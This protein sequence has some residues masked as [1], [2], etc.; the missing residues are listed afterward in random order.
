MANE[1]E[2]GMTPAELRQR[3]KHLGLSQSSLADALGVARNTVAR[4]E[5]GEL[6]IGSPAMV[7]LAG[8]DPVLGLFELEGAGSGARDRGDEE[9][10]LRGAHP[11]GHGK[12]G[13]VGSKGKSAK[14]LREMLRRRVATATPVAFGSGTLR[15]IRR[16][17]PLCRPESTS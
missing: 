3:R 4:W 15:S 5:R 10:D 9:D 16:R 12:G 8:G 1:V 17:V 6:A 2:R 14:D 13:A 7:E 11:P